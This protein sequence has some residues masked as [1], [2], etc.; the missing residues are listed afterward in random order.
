MNH[1]YN[2]GV[3]VEL[4]ELVENGVKL[5]DFDYPSFYTGEAKT[6]FEQKVIDHYYFRQI[7]QETPARFMHY[8]RTRIREIMPYYIQLY[9]S[10]RM[11]HSVEDPFKSYDLTETFTSERS[12]SHSN[13][14]SA[15]SSDSSETGSTGSNSSAGTDDN[16]HTGNNQ[17]IFSDTPQG[18][19]SN[20]DDH[21]TEATK[22]SVS[23]TDRRT[24]SNA[25]ESSTNTNY[26][27]SASSEAS[28]SGESSESFTH[29]LHRYGNIGVQP[30]G[31]EI[32]A[33]RSALL[34]ID[35]MIIDELND[36]FLLVY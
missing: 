31:Q 33:Y 16:T 10:E 11:M 5:W 34:N 29:T 6:A 14:S 2:T 7:G 18:N 27:G 8:F 35:K 22:E 25:V 28:D 17:R 26:S 4:R 21:M 24:M 12:G 20:L 36:L 9:E 1:Y 23:A 32:N 13:E 30:L 3:T 15:S 19:I